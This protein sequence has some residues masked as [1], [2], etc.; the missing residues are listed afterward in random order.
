MKEKE[1]KSRWKMTIR[2]TIR[3]RRRVKN[4]EQE[5]DKRNMFFSCG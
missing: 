2:R 5:Y 3:N 4:E 1:E